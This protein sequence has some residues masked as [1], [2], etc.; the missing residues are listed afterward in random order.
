MTFD[1]YQVESRKTAIYPRRDS[2]N[3]MYPA[4]GLTSEAGEVAGKLKKVIR[5]MDGV[6]DETTRTEVA[7]EMGDVMWYVS[8]LASELK[9]N[10]NDIA[11]LNLDRLADRQKRGKL[12][13]SG[14]NR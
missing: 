5:D 3:F 14:D 7:K 13:G 4:L 11:Q 6:I 1:D 8:Q 10:L 9:L 2:E 12:G